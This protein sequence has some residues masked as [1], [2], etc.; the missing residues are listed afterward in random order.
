MYT[1]TLLEN[2]TSLFHVNSREYHILAVKDQG[3]MLMYWL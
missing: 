3:Y 1:R 2:M